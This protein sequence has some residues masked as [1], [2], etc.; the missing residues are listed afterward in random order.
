MG[1]FLGTI[2]DYG[3]SSTTHGIKYIV[4]RRQVFVHRVLWFLIVGLAVSISSHLQDFI[5][6]FYFITF[7]LRFRF[8]FIYWRRGLDSLSDLG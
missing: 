7:N 5:H 3:E 8:I 6:Y 2:Q 1:A 4:E